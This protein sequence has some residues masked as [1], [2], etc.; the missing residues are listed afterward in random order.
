MSF[1]P[2]ICGTNNYDSN[3]SEYPSDLQC[4]NCHNNSVHAIKRR[5]FFTIWFIPLVPMYWGKQLACTICTWR[6][7]VSTS[8]LEKYQ[9]PKK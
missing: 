6:Q 5:E 8:D 3:L 4:P 1:V 2:L 7:D 9:I